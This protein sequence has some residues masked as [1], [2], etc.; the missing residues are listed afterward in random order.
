MST[1]S[2]ECDPS[3][4]RVCSRQRSCLQRYSWSDREIKGG[5]NHPN[6]SSLM[7]ET[8]KTIILKPEYATFTSTHADLILTTSTKGGICSY[9]HR[10]WS[11][12]IHRMPSLCGTLGRAVNKSVV[13][14]H[15]TIYWVAALSS[16]VA[17]SWSLVTEAAASTLSSGLLA[18]PFCNSATKTTT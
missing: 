9:H 10:V 14:V 4:L 13:H 15:L 1:N 6:N 5:S 11:A 16:L 2:Y 12:N 18:F 7:V 8:C 3:L 17:Y